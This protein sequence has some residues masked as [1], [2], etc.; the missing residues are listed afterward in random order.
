MCFI[1]V[2]ITQSLDNFTASGN[3]LYVCHDVLLVRTLTCVGYISL[4]MCILL[5][6]LILHD[7]MRFK[8]GRVVKYD[9]QRVIRKAEDILLLSRFFEHSGCVLLSEQASAWGCSLLPWKG[10][11]IV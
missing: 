9:T 5:A 2:S 3:V 8:S 11:G 10:L 4:L 7:G 6:Q 1:E